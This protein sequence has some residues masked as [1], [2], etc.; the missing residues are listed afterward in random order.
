MREGVF[1][2][3]FAILPKKIAIFPLSGVLLLPRGRLPLNIFEPR[4]M[5]MT[6]DA[7]GNRRILG[8]VQPRLRIGI[9]KHEG[10]SM[11]S[12]QV[13]QHGC[14]G[15]IVSFNETE[16]GRLLI[17]LLGLCRFRILRELKLAEGGYRQVE[18]DYH[19]FHADMEEEPVGVPVVDRK[20]L[21]ACLRPY[22]AQHHITL[23]WKVL[24]TLSEPALI[25]AVAMLCPFDTR[26]KQA[27]LE[28]YTVEERGK[29]L[30]SL[31]EMSLLEE[32]KGGIA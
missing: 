1:D 5:A 4:Y 13:Y 18:V 9:G 17:T 14:A 30:I 27:L 25:T 10:E 24:D 2:L 19:S 26:E 29:L 28:I 12:A 21:L 15:R 7:L 32:G 8:M 31:I 3:Q 20:R 11:G 23:N 22:C 16:D 6:L